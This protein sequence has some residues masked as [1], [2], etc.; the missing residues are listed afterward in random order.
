MNKNDNNTYF[1]SP[2][3]TTL[4]LYLNAYFYMQNYV[5]MAP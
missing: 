4:K 3:E 5:L 2:L 1:F